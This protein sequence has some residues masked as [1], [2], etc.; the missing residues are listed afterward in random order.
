MRLTPAEKKVAR[1]L[2]SGFTWTNIGAILG[3]AHNTVGAHFKAIFKKSGTH[4]SFEFAMKVIH[5]EAL[6]REVMEAE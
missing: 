1:H 6:L 4:S 2:L 3:I 5:S